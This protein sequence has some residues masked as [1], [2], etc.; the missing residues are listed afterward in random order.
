MKRKTAVKKYVEI[1]NIFC[2]QERTNK[3]QLVPVHPFP[4]S[5]K[6][7][8]FN[9]VAMTVKQ[10]GG[11]AVCC[12]DVSRNLTDYIVTFNAHFIWKREDGQLLDVSPNNADCGTSCVLPI[13]TI[14]SGKLPP[15]RYYPLI[16]D[17]SI[18]EEAKTREIVHKLKNEI[19][20]FVGINMTEPKA[21]GWNEIQFAWDCI[22]P[23]CSS[24]VIASRI[25]EELMN[26][27]E[28]GR[29]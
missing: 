25:E 26:G 12:W 19:L 17:P 8:C 9:N 5:E 16:N 18:V 14:W 28:R 6:Y 15:S 4:K 2:E 24:I 3:P 11:Q 29:F 20:D 7:F 23:K 27:F 22:K 1:I 21:V 10:C 13:E